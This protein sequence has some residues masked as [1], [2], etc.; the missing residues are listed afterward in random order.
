MSTLAIS[1][2][3]M[4]YRY[5]NAPANYAGLSIAQ[6]N[7]DITERVFLHGNS[8]TGKT[9]LLNLLCGILIPTSG[10]VSLFNN[11]ISRLSN[12]QRDLFRAKNIG[13]VSQKFNLIPYL[14]VLK[15][16][17]LA[18]YFVKNSR[19]EVNND[20]KTLL[21]ALQ[22]PNNIIHRPVNQLSAG[23]QQRIAIARA[24]INNPRLLLVDEPTSALDTSAK[25]AFMDLLM[26]MCDNTK[27]T[28]VFVSHDASLSHHFDSNL[29]ITSLSKT[30]EA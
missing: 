11:N 26:Q 21:N 6:W 17:Q 10:N 13:V 4:N 3:D 20:V 24:L 28:L 19:P 8:G 14:S 1:L 12:S 30:E 16:I 2:K 9:T 23:Q 29:D 18:A 7:V 22:L 27:M 15:N 5:K 25:N